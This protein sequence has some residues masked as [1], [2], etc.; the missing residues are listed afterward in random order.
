[1]IGTSDT[2]RTTSIDPADLLDAVVIGGGVAGLSGAVALARVG[3]SVVVV[4]AG[5]PRNAPTDAI[6][7]L[8]GQEGLGSLELLR[9]GATR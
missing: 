1:M 8:L 4:D 9:R 3:R 6:H 5:A 2:T 7:G